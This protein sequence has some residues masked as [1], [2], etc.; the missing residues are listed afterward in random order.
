ML[1]T[2]LNLPLH[3]IGVACKNLEKER[4]CFFKLGFYKESEFIDEK[5][6][7]RGE[8]IIP[9]NEAFPQYRFELL[10]NLNDKGPLDSYLKNN[11]KMYHLAYESKY[12]PRF[13]SFGT[14]RRHLYCSYYASKL[15]C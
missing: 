2:T 9:C 11:T 6:G 3:H 5:Q 12:R 14:T 4:E 7:V 13:N 1:N 15:F 8:F 10:Q